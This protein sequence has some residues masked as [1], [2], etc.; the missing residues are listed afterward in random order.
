MCTETVHSE[1]TPPVVSSDTV[2]TD[3]FNQ[4]PAFGW[5][6]MTFDQW[7]TYLCVSERRFLVQ[8][9]TLMRL[10]DV[11][12]LLGLISTAHTWVQPVA[13]RVCLG[14]QSTIA[15]NY[16]GTVSEHETISQPLLGRGECLFPCKATTSS[17]SITVPQH[18]RSEHEVYK[19]SVCATIRIHCLTIFRLISCLIYRSVIKW[20]ELLKPFVS[21]YIFHDDFM[22]VFS[23]LHLSW[24]SIMKYSI[25]VLGEYHGFVNEPVSFDRLR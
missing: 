7:R 23:K 21:H 8:S 3:K 2:P 12:A 14:C 20:D 19:L 22:G 11:S 16:Q 9:I 17:R 1:F 24:F 6:T 25:K 13:Q 5:Q 4:Q 18:K 15:L 10:I